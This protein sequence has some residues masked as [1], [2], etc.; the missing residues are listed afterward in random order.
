MTNTEAIQTIREAKSKISE[1][2][3]ELVYKSETCIS[4]GI[5]WVRYSDFSEI[6]DKLIKINAALD[7]LAVEPSEEAKDLVWKII[8]LWDNA[9]EPEEYD[10]AKD[11]AAAIITAD[12][13]RIRREH[14]RLNR[15]LVSAIKEALDK[16]RIG[17]EIK[18][19]WSYVHDAVTRLKTALKWNDSDTLVL[20]GEK[21]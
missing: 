18:S 11:K 19:D 5:H 8:L 20:K 13:E 10:K 3:G 21:K 2:I 7:S 9:I 1:C 14:E 4:D 6:A 17:D 12:R 16:I 15:N